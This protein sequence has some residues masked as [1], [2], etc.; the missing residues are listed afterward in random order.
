MNIFDAHIPFAVL[1]DLAEGRTEQ[2]VDMQ[3]L[4]SCHR[5]A[6]ELKRIQEAIMSMRA[7]VSEDA[8]RDIIARAIALARAREP[9]PSSLRRLVALLSF[10]SLTVA[11][12]FGV[13]SG[14]GA[15]RQLIYIAAKNDLDLRIAPRGDE[16]VVSGQVL[17]EA[18]AGGSVEITG[19]GKSNSA[20]LNELCEFA[21]EPVPAGIYQIRFRL[22]DVEVEIPSINLTS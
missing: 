12:S 2:S 4:S 16:W 1:A 5:C 11:P 3:H 15:A 21:L 13:R 7:D 14:E 20:K 8:P 6:G 9:E 22:A 18:C 10:D 17:G 19:A